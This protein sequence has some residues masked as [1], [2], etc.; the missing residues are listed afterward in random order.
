MYK[1]QFK[2]N[3]PYDWFCGPGS[4]M[5][6][7]FDVRGQ[8]EQGIDFFTGWSLIMDYGHKQWFKVEMP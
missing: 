6:L 5:W 1:Y 8:Q 7:G 2:K 3:Y 4:H